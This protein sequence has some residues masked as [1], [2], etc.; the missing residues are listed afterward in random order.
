MKR[1][2]HNTRD[3]DAFAALL[4]HRKLPVTVTVETGRKRTTEQNNLQRLWCAEIAEQI[5][6]TAEEVRGL[7]KLEFGVPI[8]RAGNDEFRAAYDRDIRPLP[9]RVKLALMMVPHD[10]EVT[11]KMNVSQK[12]EYLNT[13]HRHFSEMGV[14]LTDP[15]ALKWGSAA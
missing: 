11:R 10:Y 1:T 3:V 4:R 12:V 13:V 7:C 9:Y 5:G 15:D 2:L 6:D 14:S 8:L